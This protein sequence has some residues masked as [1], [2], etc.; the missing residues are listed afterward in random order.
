RSLQTEVSRSQ[1]LNVVY[2]VQ[3]R[4]EPLSL[5]PP[6]C[7]TYPL[8]RWTCRSGPE[9]GTCYARASFPWPVPFPP[10]PPW[11]QAQPRSA[12]SQVQ[13]N[14]PTSRARASSG[15]VLRLS[16]AVCTSL[17]HRQTRDLPA[18]AQGACVHAQGLRPRRVQR[19]LALATPPVLPSA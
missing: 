13:W 11:P 4:S 19:R 17:S 8:K 14:C 12:A 7:L 6:C 1:T 3:E 2:M 5:I 18:S 15:Y 9:S 10:P 16:D